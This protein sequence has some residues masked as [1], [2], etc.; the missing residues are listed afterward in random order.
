VKL[1][2]AAALLGSAL[3]IQAQT[4]FTGWPLFADS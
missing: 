2:A 4:T 3:V 1:F